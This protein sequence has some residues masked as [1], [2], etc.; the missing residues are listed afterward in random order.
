MTIT[1]SCD[2]RKL[3]FISEGQLPS[4][5][6]GIARGTIRFSAALKPQCSGKPRAEA[7][8]NYSNVVVTANLDDPRSTLLAFWQ[9]GIGLQVATTVMLTATP[10]GEGISEGVNDVGS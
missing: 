8:G 3:L 5:P 7:R 4:C 9:V 1:V 6:F 10:T 2:S